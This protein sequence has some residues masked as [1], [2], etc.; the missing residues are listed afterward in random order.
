M[1]GFCCET[2]VTQRRRSAQIKDN[3][4]ERIRRQ[5]MMFG[6]QFLQGDAGVF[7]PARGADAMAAAM[8]AQ[9]PGWRERIYAPLDTL[10][11]FV[12]QVLSVRSR[13]SGCGGAAAI[14]AYCTRPIGKRLHDR[15]L[16]RC[17]AAIAACYTDHAWQRARRAIGMVGVG[18][19]ALARTIC[20]II[21]RHHRVDARHGEQSEGLSAKS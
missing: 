5:A 3:K 9:A 21:R 11:L 14:G 20:Q 2:K 12:G 4:I 16:L 6:R 17:K 8:S 10:R 15:L 18:A 1:V 19:L 7:D 13:L